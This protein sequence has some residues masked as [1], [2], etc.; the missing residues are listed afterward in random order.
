MKNSPTSAV[1]EIKGPSPPFGCGSDSSLTYE[2]YAA[3]TEDQKKDLLRDIAFVDGKYYIAHLDEKNRLS[4][5]RLL[6]PMHYKRMS[7][8]G[9]TVYCGALKSYVLGYSYDPNEHYWWKLP[10][11][12]PGDAWA[13]RPKFLAT[14]SVVKQ[15]QVDSVVE[16]EK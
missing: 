10:Q 13:V 9:S 2:E 8:H 7:P 5:L 16:K 14:V 11:K 6:E 4:L 12:Y 3:L 1:S 15:Q